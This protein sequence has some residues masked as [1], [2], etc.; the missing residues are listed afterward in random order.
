V[1]EEIRQL[2]QGRTSWPSLLEIRIAALL[3]RWSASYYD[4]QETVK[5]Y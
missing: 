4:H 5:F 3:W 1:F 2:E